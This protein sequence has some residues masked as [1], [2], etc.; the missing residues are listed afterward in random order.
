MSNTIQSPAVTNTAAQITRPKSAAIDD[1]GAFSVALSNVGNG[2]PYTDADVKQFFAGNPSKEQI[3]KQAAN[4]G[5]SEAQVMQ[6][7]RVGGYGGNSESN[8]KAGI[9]GYVSDASHGYAW[10]TSGRLVDTRV[11]KTAT[12]GG[13]KGDAKA[14]PSEQSI[15]A[16]FATGPSETEQAGMA[17]NLGLTPAQMV[18]MQVTG[19]GV[20]MNRMQAD[21]LESMYVAAAKSLGT[22]IGG[23]SEGI[24]GSNGGW[25]SYFSPTLGRAIGP[26][27]ISQFFGTNPTQAQIFQKASQLGIGVSAINNMMAGQGMPLT[28]PIAGSAF[29]RMAMSLYQ[30]TDGYSVDQQGHIVAGGGKIYAANPDGSYSWSPKNTST[31]A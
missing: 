27:E 19:N 22:D 29:N 20:V 7:M 14:M 1:S 10:D 30:G 8:L 12:Q 16:F 25:T 28:D 17:K 3:A 21:V 4:L 9:D 2:T 13:V 31:L 18:Q 24:G 23:K 15:K 11:V 26:D 6:A 5:M